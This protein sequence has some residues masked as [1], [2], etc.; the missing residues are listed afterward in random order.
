[1]HRP[2]TFILVA[3]ALTACVASNGDEGILITK[4]VAVGDACTFNASES[5]PF[6]AHGVYSILSPAAYEVHPQMKS[7]V[8]AASGQEDQRTIL[9]KGAHVSLEFQDAA[10]S[11]FNQKFDTL[12]SAPISPNGGITDAAFAGIPV[13]VL[14]QL[15]ASNP[16]YENGSVPL[17]TEVLVK[18]VVF[19][20]M[21]GDE[22]VSQQWQFPVT[23]CNNCVVNIMGACPVD[24]MATVRT[25]NACNPFQDG[26]VDCCGTVDALVC[27]AIKATM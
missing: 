12:F 20:E 23:I 27:P 22:V 14:D 15:I 2:F 10:F 13:S 5:S 4:N 3:S 17:Q 11:S 8:T 19:G 9:V 25:G 16:G 7:R 26:V 21:G 6:I 18:A 24:R 1:M